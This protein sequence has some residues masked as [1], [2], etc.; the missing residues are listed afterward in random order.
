MLIVGT[1]DETTPQTSLPAYAAKA[2]SCGYVKRIRKVAKGITGFRE[3]SDP[4]VDL[5]RSW[6][7]CCPLQE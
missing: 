4:P 3:W 1:P 5:V 6:G 7:P 2:Y